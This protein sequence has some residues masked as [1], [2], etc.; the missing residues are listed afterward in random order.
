MKPF[1]IGDIF[2]TE[3]RYQRVKVKRVK[4]KINNQQ[5][6]H[7]DRFTRNMF[8][9]DQYGFLNQRHGYNT[10]STYDLA[11]LNSYDTFESN[12]LNNCSSF[13]SDIHNSNSSTNSVIKQTSY[14]LLQNINTL[15]KEPRYK[16]LEKRLISN[17]PYK[18]LDAPG[19]L[20]DYYLNLLDWSTNNFISIGLTEDLYIYDVNNKNVI[21]LTSLSENEYFTSLKSRDNR[22]ATGT[23]KGDIFIYDIAACK[24]IQSFKNHD[25]RVAS[26]DWNENIL[27]SGSRNGD[28]LNYD[29]RDN[30]IVNIWKKHTQEI[31]GLKWSPNKKYL[32]SGSNDNM[33]YIWQMGTKSPRYNFDEHSSAVKALDWCPWKTNILVSGGGS[34]DKTVRFWDITTG[35]CDRKFSVTSQVCNIHFINKYKE[36]ITTHGFL[37]NNICLWKESNFKL[38]SSFGKHDS[39]VL[40]S[41]ISPDQSSFISLAGD[42][43]LKFWKIYEQTETK[44]IIENTEVNL[45]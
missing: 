7:E 16:R 15:A 10:H 42:E 41:A 8:G 29:I 30:K 44:G 24:K 36:I 4:K 27:T 28:I 43:N 35:K 31:C 5:L 22:L 39:R 19:I 45:R 12:I 34:N 1:D 40:Y 37:E 23:S 6:N 21:N 26:L 25:T 38:I 18:I 11:C 33:L 20:S 3:P 13:G 9:S 2:N 32:A 14:S 17:H